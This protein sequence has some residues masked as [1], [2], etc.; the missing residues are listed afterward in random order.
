MGKYQEEVLR[1][2]ILSFYF[3]V[4]IL[5][6]PRDRRSGAASALSAY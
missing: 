6:E 5:R 3:I 1:I 2:I 4:V